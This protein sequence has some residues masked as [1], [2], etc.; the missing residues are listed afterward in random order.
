ME[1]FAREERMYLDWLYLNYADKDQS[2]LRSIGAE[3]I[4]LIKQPLSGMIFMVHHK[5][6][7][8]VSSYI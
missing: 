5:R 1:G 2:T 3:N 6:V 7:A 8:W 4:A